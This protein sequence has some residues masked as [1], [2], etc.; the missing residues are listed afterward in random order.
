MK[1]SFTTVGIL[2]S[3]LAFSQ[4]KKDSTE[5]KS[6]KEVVLVG[7]KPTVENKVDRTVFNVA[8]SS[9]LAG[10]TTWD[11]LKMAPLVSIDNN[12]VLKAEG[13]NVTVYINDRKSVFSG[14]ELK[15]YLK[16]IPADF[17][18][19]LN[20]CWWFTRNIISDSIDSFHFI[21]NSVRYIF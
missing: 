10:N 1:K 18:F 17:L 16:T 11:V 19:P 21:D 8:N 15:E 7:K 14:K 20:R 2:C 9:I 5:Q 4:T 3:F 13:E 12:D 6:I